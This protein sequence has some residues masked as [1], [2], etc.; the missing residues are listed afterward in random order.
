METRLFLDSVLG[1]SGNYCLFG[2]RKASPR[3]VQKF[4]PSVG[5]LLQAADDLDS[6]GYDTY[7]ALGTFDSAESRKASNVLSLSS[8]FLDLDCGP[9]KDY[10]TQRDAIIGLQSFCKE[11]KLPKPTIINSGRGVHVYWALHDPVTPEEWLPVAQCLKQACSTHG[12]SCR[13]SRRS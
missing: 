6:Q 2:A 8:L 7:F 4:Y 11:L 10:N 3:I 1:G 13:N 9:S 12:R 5:E